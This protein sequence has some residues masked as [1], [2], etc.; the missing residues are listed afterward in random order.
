MFDSLN[1]FIFIAL[2]IT[3]SDVLIWDRLWKPHFILSINQAENGVAS[4]ARLTARLHQEVQRVCR[5]DQVMSAQS[6][7]LEFRSSTHITG[8]Y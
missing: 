1:N 7:S 5:I 4:L 3:R 6:S 2:L 8:L